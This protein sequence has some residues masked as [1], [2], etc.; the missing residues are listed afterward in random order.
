MLVVLV[1]FDTEG[2][3][4][5]DAPVGYV[6]YASGRG[7]SQRRSRAYTTIRTIIVARRS[8]KDLVVTS[9][10]VRMWAIRHT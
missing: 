10:S 9:E 8:S 3:G 5:A 4:A 2:T 7:A 1:K 6:R